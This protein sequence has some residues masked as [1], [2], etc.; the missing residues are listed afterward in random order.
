MVGLFAGRLGYDDICY[1][2][3]KESMTKTKRTSLPR[4]FQ[5]PSKENKKNFDAIGNEESPHE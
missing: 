3:G 4:A 1:D 2:Y 5:E